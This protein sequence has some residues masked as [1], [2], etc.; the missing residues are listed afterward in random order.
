M[1]T[2]HTKNTKTSGEK[3]Y[4]KQKLNYLIMTSFFKF[5]VPSFYVSKVF[6]IESSL[7]KFH[8]I[9]VL[10]H[11]TK[12]STDFAKQKCPPSFDQVAVMT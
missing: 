9:N 5:Q 7:V 10:N 3:R 1:T 12:V 4:N 11:E 2:E 8:R 6:H